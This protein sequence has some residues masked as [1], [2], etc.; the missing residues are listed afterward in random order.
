MKRGMLR[1]FLSRSK[2]R[3]DYAITPDNK[4][5]DSKRHDLKVIFFLSADYGNLGDIAIS[6][7]QRKLLKEQYPDRKYIEIS[8]N[9][10]LSAIKSLRNRVSERDIITIVGGGNTGDMYGYIENRRRLVIKSFPHNR[11]ICF[12]QT[13]DFSNTA[14]GRSELRRSVRIYSA[15]QYL[16]LMVREQ[17]SFDFVE[18]YFKTKNLLTPDIVLSLQ[19][20]KV[21]KRDKNKL[22]FCIRNDTEIGITQH[23]RKRM[24]NFFSKNYSKVIYQDTHIGGGSISSEEGDEALRSIWEVFRTADMVITD[25]LHGMIFCVITKTPCIALNNSN[26]KV[27]GVY[28]LWIK[29]LG[30]VILLEEFTDNA[31]QVAFDSV[32][33]SVAS[34]TDELI[35]EFDV[36][37]K[38][39]Y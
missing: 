33:K 21:Q 24:I 30:G 16:T 17:R 20:E 34:G 18:K 22:V 31:M 29:R 19:E 7:A 26:G 3:F 6:Y 1:S 14:N 37:R 8:M 35:S 9:D 36:I 4:Y 27:K 39:L 10:T 5:S 2:L 15:H 23:E 38:E 11:I 32:K 25:R 13:V 28:D 12:P